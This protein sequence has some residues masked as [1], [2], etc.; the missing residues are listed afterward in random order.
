MV[1]YR[2]V[3]VVGKAGQTHWNSDNKINGKKN[4][5]NKQN[6]K[7]YLYIK[8]NYTGLVAVKD[9]ET[10]WFC[11]TWS[12]VHLMVVLLHSAIDGELRQLMHSRAA[13]ETRI[14]VLKNIW[15]ITKWRVKMLSCKSIKELHDS[16][17]VI[18]WKHHKISFYFDLWNTFFGYNLY[19]YFEDGGSCIL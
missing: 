12:S 8:K 16:F 1:N 2:H 11:Y 18:V 9:I 10:R 4:K 17:T 15:H 14:S 13:E 3:A 5:L 6:K 7:R 19:V